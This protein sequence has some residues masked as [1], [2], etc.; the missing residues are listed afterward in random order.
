M[1]GGTVCACANETLRETTAGQTLQKPYF[2]SVFAGDQTGLLFV[3]LPFVRF[4]G[5][6]LPST[7]TE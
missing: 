5:G 2:F 6:A 1:A 7:G 3:P 4:V